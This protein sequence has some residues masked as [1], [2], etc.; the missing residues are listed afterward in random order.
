MSKKNKTRKTRKK[1]QLKTRRRWSTKRKILLAIL[2]CSLIG[3]FLFL[4]KKI[5]FY[6]STFNSEQTH[7]H[8]TNSPSEADRIYR[9]LEKN[10]DYTFGIDLSHYQ[11]PDM[12]NWDSLII[13]PSGL[14][15]DFVILR[16][17]MGT[18]GRDNQ[19]EDYWQDA[20]KSGIVRGAYHF[21][22]PDEDPI[23]QANNFLSTVKLESGDL[24][25]VLD[26]E[27]F[28]KKL[29]KKQFLKNVK[30]WLKIVEEAYGQK[31][32]IYTYYHFYKDNLRDEDFES[33]PLWLAN[34]NNV[35][36]PSPEDPWDMWQFT[37]NGI[38]KGI[39][40]KVDLN[41]FK[42]SLPELQNISIP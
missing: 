2:I 39:T 22:R 38:T 9:I 34:Y 8:L 11:R 5:S 24:I 40:T 28:P 1:R 36:Q 42:G 20:K 35:S 6:F 14:P 29:S 13:S 32:M 10:L 12:I 41:I 21:Y 3:T 17:T 16:A 30:I 18:A 4:G 27:R 7:R 19:F 26:V 23:L 33:Y 15:I 37:E 25:P 31:P